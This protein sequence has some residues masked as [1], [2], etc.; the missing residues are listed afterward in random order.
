MLRLG[1][2][3]T[4]VYLDPT[5]DAAASPELASVVSAIRAWASDADAVMV[6]LGMGGH[7]DHL[8]CAEAGRLLAREPGSK[9]SFYEDRPYVSFCS[10]DEVVA[11]AAAVGPSLVPVPVS[12][13]ISAAKR[14][15]LFYP[16]QIDAN[17]ER[18][19]RIDVDGAH[20]ERVWVDPTI[21]W[22]TSR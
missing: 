4:T 17:F 14:R 18:A 15:R 20:R 10:A 21:G 12:G 9:V 22:P 16:S 6:P 7:V 19:L 8:L 13:P 2:T 5:F 1:T 3:D 11:R